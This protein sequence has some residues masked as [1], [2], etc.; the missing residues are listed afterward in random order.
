MFSLPLFSLGMLDKPPQAP[1][2]CLLRNL[3]SFVFGFR[4][5]E[6]SS[7]H[8]SVL[9]QCVFDLRADCAIVRGDFVEV[10]KSQRRLPSLSA[11]V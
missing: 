11:R 9:P 1:L 4:P 2:L 8:H 7:R 5:F 6:W 10:A 3:H